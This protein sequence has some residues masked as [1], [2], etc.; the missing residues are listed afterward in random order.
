MEELKTII[1][2]VKVLAAAGADKADVRAFVAHIEQQAQDVVKKVPE[3][4]PYYAAI[5]EELKP[6]L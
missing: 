1:D 4:A 2:L 3:M 5:L 6:L